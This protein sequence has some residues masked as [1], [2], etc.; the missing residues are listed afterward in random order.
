MR[1][2]VIGILAHV[3][4]GKT[5]LSEGMLY[6]AGSIRKLGRVDH[7]DAFLDNFNMEKERGI[8]IFS[9]QAVFEWNDVNITLLDT[10]GHVDFSSE[11]ERTLQVLDYAILVISGT[12][13]VQSHTETLWRL[14]EKY[15]IPVFIFVNKMDLAGADFE[16]IINELKSELAE[17]IIDF[18]EKDKDVLNENIA[19]CDEGIM[20][21]Y[22]E[23]GEIAET[24][25]VNCNR[26]MKIFPIFCG[27][28]LKME[29]V[30]EFLNAFARLT[31]QKTAFPIFG[32]K[33]FKISQDEKGQRLTFLKV[34]GGELKVKNIIKYGE[35]CEKINE[36]RIYSGD[37]YNNIDCA[38][39][40]CVCAVTGLS[41]SYAGQGLGFEADS[42]KL[43]AEPI[44]NYRV[45]LPQGVD[46]S[47]ALTNFKRLQEEE[48]QLNVTW[49]EQLQEIQ[50]RLMGE[51]QLEVLKQMILNRFGMWV[52]FEE[53]RLVYKE[54]IE[55]TVEG[56][57]HYEPLRHY[58]EGHLLI[59][60]LNRGMGVHFATD[61]P[62]DK[63]DK[64]WQRLIMTHLM[65]KSH[66]GVL[67][68]SPITDVKITLKSG[69]AHLK[70]TEGGDFR[71]ATYRAVRQGLWWAKSVLLEPYYEFVLEVPSENIG[72]AMTDL[73]TF[74]AEFSVPETRGSMSKI[75]GTVPAATM[76][77]YQRELIAYTHGKG[78][79]S[80]KFSGYDICQN[81]EKIIEEIG[82]NPDSDM[83]NTADSVFCS[84]GAGYNVKWNEVPEH[85]HLESVLKP[86][87]TMNEEIRTTS[88]KSISASDE[89]LLKIFERTYG[90]I[91]RK[92]PNHTMRT[93]KPVNSVAYKG[94]KVNFDYDKEYLLIDGY[95][96]IFAWEDLKVIA[97]DNLESARA[98]LVERISAYK[99]FRDIEVIVV[100]DAYRVKG[101]I[102]EVE[103]IDGISVV[104]TKEAQTADSY[105]EKTAKELSKKYRVTVATS[106]GLEQ[107]IIFGSGA[108]RLSAQALREEVCGVE[109]HI[110]SMVKECNIKAESADIMRV[111][112]EKLEEIE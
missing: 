44:F 79:L 77:N 70:H 23:T 68:G 17:N 31:M 69:A 92:N 18:S 46:T 65:E 78:K 15:N 106:D 4:A 55:N 97:K 100:F 50:I 3:D 57:G 42:D 56:V 86:K 104:Y 91:E 72:R 108:F 27:A 111:L 74:G 96:I 37:K 63:L 109:N 82:Y 58:A 71:Q 12:D 38:K 64:N 75:F 61:C 21:K 90:K 11:M 73:N 94:K 59:E 5:T 66:I 76:Q 19:V 16:K 85:M 39:P 95:N 84:H 49:N 30:E 99:L 51:I 29:G 22:L 60:P 43:T 35:V 13:G 101:N 25:I 88:A 52:E 67:T 45:I 14:L 83:E 62:E 110:R 40:G 87:K 33:V 10:P 80:L 105:I 98:K 34:T 112:R 81:A 20:E 6:T 7:K 102:G 9:K 28:A 107:L 53:G 47:T 26:L 93:P 41:K 8:T 48:T 103:N 24:E 2:T 54:T 89:E 1:K 36:I 32:A